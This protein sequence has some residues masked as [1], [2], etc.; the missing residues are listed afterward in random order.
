MQMQRVKEVIEN[1]QWKMTKM[2]KS[3]RVTPSEQR[4]EDI[5][6]V[7]QEANVTVTSDCFCVESLNGGTNSMFSV[8]I[9]DEKRMS[10]CLSRSAKKIIFRIFGE[11]TE[12]LIDR[13]REL[14]KWCP[15]GQMMCCSS[16]SGAGLDTMLMETLLICKIGPF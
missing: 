15:G 2:S 7:L 1:E 13:N 16:M 11:Q 12:I 10:W 6:S 4:N 8:Q 5:L 3:V 14:E 9:G